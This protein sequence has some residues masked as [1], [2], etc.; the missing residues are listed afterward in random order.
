[1]S[2]LYDGTKTHEVRD[3][4]GELVGEVRRIYDAEL[5]W[6]WRAWVI[7][8]DHTGYHKTKLG[9]H[10]TVSDAEDEIRRYWGMT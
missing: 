4:D 7:R 2:D 3:E 8:D 6:M 10:D 9:L 5:G 1:M